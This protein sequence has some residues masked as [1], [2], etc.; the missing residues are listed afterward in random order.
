MAIRKVA[1][2]GHPVLRK[3]ARDLKPEEIQSAEIQQL[4]EDMKA[5][6]REYGGIGIAAP[7]VH[8][9]V[10]LA[11]IDLP[12]S[13]EEPGQSLTV[14]VNP[15]IKVLDKEE[16]GYWE[17]CLSVPE[18]RGL[19]FRPR[20]VEVSYLDEKGKK[21]SFVAEDFLATVVQH[22]LDHLQGILFVD[23][24]EDMTKLAFLEEYQRYCLPKPEDGIGE[25]GD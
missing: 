4:I 7:Q 5:T 23:R 11:L 16:Q 15:K 22:E 12:P 18:L 2:M 25:L 21:Q 20:K 14:F 24:I 8:E 10:Q 13:A 9:S 17:G 6:M 19:V 1:R 3:V